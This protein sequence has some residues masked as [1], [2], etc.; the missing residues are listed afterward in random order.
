M[1]R[2][3]RVPTTWLVLVLAFAASAPL[4][5]VAADADATTSAIDVTAV[6]PWVPADGDF[7]VEMRVTGSVPADASVRT[8]IH[9]RLRARGRASLRD[10]LDDVLDGGD[11]PNLLQ[12][13]TTRPIAEL[14]DPTVGIVIDVPVRST[15]AQPDDRVLLPSPGIHPVTID[16]L[17]AAGAS[18]ATTTVFL[19][20][21]PAPS[22]TNGAGL[23]TMAVA[24]HTVV[25]GPTAVDPDGRSQISRATRRSLSAVASLLTA[26]PQA[27]LSVAIRPTLLRGLTRSTDSEDRRILQS[28]QDAWKAPGHAFV[29]SRMPDVG[30]DTGGL[31]ATTDG[32]GEVLRQ[33]A[34][35]DDTVRTVL[36]AAPSAAT[37]FG[38]PTVTTQ[39][40]G[41]LQG[42]GVQRLA[43]SGDRLRMLTRGVDDDALTTRSVHLDPSGPTATATDAAASRRL[44]DAEVAAGLRA[45]QVATTL[46]AT[47]FSAD[48]AGSAP[49]APVAVLDVAPNTPPE[50]LRPLVTAF[51]AP[52]PLSA[53]PLAV[54][55]VAT[56]RDDRPISAELT[57]RSTPDQ[58]PA[59]REVVES[60]RLIEG[61]KSMAPS[62]TDQV[63]EWEMLDAQTLDRSLNG[64]ARDSYHVRIAGGIADQTGRIDMPRQ[65]RI[66]LTSR[67]ST[68]PLR[69]RNRLPYDVS[70]RLRTRS[71]RLDIDGGTERTVVLHPGE[72][73]IDLKVTTR[74]PGATLLRVDATSPDGTLSIPSI[75]IP[76][77]SSTISGVGAALSALSLL[78]LAIWWFRTV[79]R[80]R[81]ARRREERRRRIASSAVDASDDPSEPEHPA[82]V[83]PPA[84]G[85]ADSVNPGG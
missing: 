56:T 3:R 21:L 2:S 73:R 14:G 49:G 38:D 1:R 28:L 59:V 39:S 57:S 45:N 12:T 48:D 66:V 60:R 74:A 47:W 34:L 5:S 72:N 63:A 43:V 80:D 81:R 62:A 19:N 20:H 51:A 54:P 70:I 33:V 27:P 41:V 83:G 79:R 36:G 24:L 78:V 7:R 32:N 4:W 65:R 53:D 9:Q 23:P 10:V 61:F 25:D 16:L 40:L 71:V 30:I 82:P 44:G 26:V 35:G 52:G 77:T 64:T 76:V 55:A 85:R 69:F 67:S 29:A 13:P 22:S 8:S 18:V 46:M 50:V 42:L 31:T 58:G 68:I 6:S 15:R 75:S 84:A 11:L 37:W 17:D